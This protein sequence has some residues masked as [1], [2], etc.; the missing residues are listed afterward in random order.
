MLSL[1]KLR[2]Y[3]GEQDHRLAVRDPF[4]LDGPLPRKLDSSF[5]GF[6]TGLGDV[7]HPNGDN[8]HGCG[9]TGQEM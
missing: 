9:G 5:H 4:D 6:G 2:T 3:L 7:D 1:R 8:M